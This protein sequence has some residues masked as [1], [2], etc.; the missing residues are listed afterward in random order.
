MGIG[1]QLGVSREGVQLKMQRQP[2]QHA[3]RAAKIH[4]TR[5]VPQ[6]RT[7]SGMLLT[8]LIQ[9]PQRSLLLRTGHS[10]STR[11]A[12]QWQ[13]TN[14]CNR[15]LPLSLPSPPLAPRQPPQPHPQLL[16]PPRRRSLSRRRRR[17]RATAI[18]NSTPIAAARSHRWQLQGQQRKL[19][20]SCS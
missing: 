11:L 1:A 5:N 13:I 3:E 8:L 16:G 17:R 14:C 2:W 12:R 7:K 20:G 6:P 19:H 15:N 9:K 10:A 18:R 4:A